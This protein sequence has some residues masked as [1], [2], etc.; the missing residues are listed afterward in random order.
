[1]KTRKLGNLTVS[2][3][4]MDCMGM[5]HAAGAPMEMGDAVRLVRQAV[6]LG[7]TFQW[8]DSYTSVRN[9]QTEELLHSF[10]KLNNVLS[11]FLFTTDCFP[12]FP[13]PA[14]LCFNAPFLIH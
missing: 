6:E 10:V 2:A 11:T 12:S 13:I 7:Y 1:M 14:K 9:L 8:T 4:G 3:I 5:S